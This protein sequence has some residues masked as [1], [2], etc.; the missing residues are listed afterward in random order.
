MEGD[1]EGGIGSFVQIWECE[2]RE[3]MLG[4]KVLRSRDI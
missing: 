1:E 2:E 4:V 3:E